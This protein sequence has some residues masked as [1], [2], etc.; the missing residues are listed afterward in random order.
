LKAKGVA[1]EDTTLKQYM[2][3]LMAGGFI[4]DAGKG[5]YSTIQ[6]AF[7]LDTKPIQDVVALLAGKFPL[8]RFA[9]WSTEQI[10]GYTHHTLNKFVTFVHVGKDAMRPIFETLRGT[11]WNAYLNPGAKEV[12]TVF[13]VRDKTIVVRQTRVP[14][15]LPEDH[16]LPVEEILVE[17]CRE[18]NRLSIMDLGDL[19]TVV[20]RVLE[21]GRIDMGTLA[22]EVAQ[23]KTGEL[24]EML[25]EYTI[26]ENE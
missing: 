6:A 5:W 15:S 16:V 13:T 1:C 7:V 20:D 10:R 14:D 12:R 8:L 21:T 18:C 3:E 9:C 22:L 17:I 24:G 26:L 2:S 25:V 19:K 11:G 23:A 4:H